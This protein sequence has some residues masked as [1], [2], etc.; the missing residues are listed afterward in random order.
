MAHKDPRKALDALRK[1]QETAG[2]PKEEGDLPA[3]TQIEIDVVGSRGKRYQHVFTYTVPTLGDQIDIGKLKTLFMPQGSGADPNAA[4]LNEQIAYLTVTI[5]QDSVPSWWVPMEMRDAAPIGAL[6]REALDYERR[7]HGAPAETRGDG[8]DEGVDVAE[9][10]S[11]AGTGTDAADG[12][13]GGGAQPP[14]QRRKTLSSSR[15]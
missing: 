13:V 1:Q 3:T 12:G 11:D 9:G 10:D 4:L 8:P 6:Y 5:D 2:S 14:A 15:G 7:F